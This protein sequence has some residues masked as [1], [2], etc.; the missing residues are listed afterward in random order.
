MDGRAYISVATALASA[1]LVLG[2][3]GNGGAAKTATVKR[4]TGGLQRPLFGTCVKRGFATPQ[5]TEITSRE[6]RGRAWSLRSS[7]TQAASR[8]SAQPQTDIVLLVEL[9]PNAPLPT[10]R[11]PLSKTTDIAGHSVVLRSPGNGTP[12]YSGQWKTGRATY[13]AVIASSNTKTRPAV[14]NVRQ[15]VACLT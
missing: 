11:D 8:R 4:P 2:C 14:E 1:L 12:A 15:L 6:T 7:R 5:I 10:K 9:G 13:T 3:G